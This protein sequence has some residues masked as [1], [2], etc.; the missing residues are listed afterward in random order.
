MAEII[1]TGDGDELQVSATVGANTLID[2]TTDA[3]AMPLALPWLVE[4]RRRQRIQVQRSRL[5]HHWHR[6]RHRRAVP[7]PQ[8]VPSELGRVG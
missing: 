6:V 2:G 1:I 8:P 3:A 4:A 7:R 5:R